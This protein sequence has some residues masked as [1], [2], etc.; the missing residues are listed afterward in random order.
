MRA[1]DR[2][3]LRDLLQLRGQAITIALVVACGIASFVS[4]FSVYRSLGDDMDR[5][6]ERNRFADVF[7]H[8]KRAPDAVKQDLERLPGVA[9]VETREVETVMLP[10]EDMSEPAVG[11]IV[12]LPSGGDPAL[13]KPYLEQGRMVEPGRAD[14]VL[15]LQSFAEAHHIKPGDHLPVVINGVLRHPR[16]VG[17]ALSPEYV[18]A[19]GPASGGISDN[20]RFAV[21]WM[22]RSA[23]APAFQMDGAFDDVLIRLAPGA[24]ERGVLA[25]VDRVLEPYG[26]E[27]AYLR[28]RQVSNLILHG[29]LQQLSSMATFVPAVFL[30]VAAFLLNVVLARLVHLQR[31]QIAALKALG[32]S[33]GRIALFYVELVG[34]IAAMG[35]ALGVGVGVYL[36]ERMLRLY[37]PYFRFP[38]LHYHLEWGVVLVA[39][40]VSVGA[41]ML[42]AIGAV[43]RI[44]TLPPAE[45][46]RP[47]APPTY[48]PSILERVGLG[49]LLDPGGRM[50][51]RE[52]GRRPWRAALSALGIAMA[53]GMLVAARF[54]YDA[55]D[56]MVGTEFETAQRDDLTVTF[57]R[58][59][60]GE[61]RR[62]IAH[63]P[64][65]TST[66][67]ELAV[68]VRVRAGP[69][70]RDVPLVGHPRGATLRRVVEWPPRLVT[71]PQ[72]GVL[73]TAKLAEVL[74]VRPGDVVEVDVL[75]GDHRKVTVPVVGL[76]REMFGMQL[77]MRLDA[78]RR[79][80][81]ESDAISAV[82]LTAEPDAIDGI[83]KRL[84]DMPQVASVTRRQDI[85][86]R[87][88]EQSAENLLTTTLILTL[89][90][91]TIAVGVVY[92][93]AR[94][95]LSM[96][97]RD[98]A[99]LR[100]LGFTRAEISR[101]LLGEL[102]IYVLLAIAPGM[103]FG[104]ALCHAITNMVEPEMF[105][106]PA[107]V[108]S[109][110]YAF[111]VGVTVLAAVLSALLVRRKLDHLDLIGVLK[112]RE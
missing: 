21:I 97:E 36:G 87:F 33:D 17:I 53:I 10:M 58:P 16:V 39:M 69:R 103:I 2:K 15:L 92:N 20:A 79:L 74:G 31:T 94:V 95:A 93:D 59:V 89:F 90:A 73:L 99:S 8:C 1:L 30:A 44:A 3:L 56:V 77:H 28:E 14:E 71:M 49:R 70:Y 111:A 102:A 18:Y 12:S 80:L 83:E 7:A 100:V 34:V 52:I 67:A 6:Y 51:L 32:Y 11:Q 38:D 76:T 41:A 55:L 78:A 96:R 88:N 35:G 86:A 85:I 57:L 46:M 9:V 64:G 22:D 105:R 107:V 65:V 37:R 63:L 27:G 62:E 54:T 110:S 13:N 43:R 84:E 4:L 48:R 112:S 29:E 45:A 82:S 108:S 61:A 5:Y 19:L 72:S 25:G 91:A 50:V 24:S 66:E 26:S 47:E 104:D 81:G 106:L 60:S 75:E 98:L 40:L 23:L 109:R 68:P 42:G 101:V